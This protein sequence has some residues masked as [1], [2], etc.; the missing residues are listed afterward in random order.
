MTS[1]AATTTQKIEAVLWDID[2]TLIDSEDLHYDV[3]A[4]WC[5][6]RGYVL[7]K[8][9]N[10][11]L[12]G[13]SMAE[14]WQYLKT[15]HDFRVDGEMFSRECA[16]MYCAALRP[17]LARTESVAVFRKIADMNIPLACVSNGDAAVVEANLEILGL[18]DLIRFSISGEDISSGKPDP[19][20]YLL[21]AKKMGVSPGNCIAVEDSLV[22]VTSASAAGMTVIAWPEPGTSVAGYEAASYFI[23]EEME[24]PWH[25][26]T[27]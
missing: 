23:R 9:D 10:A 21:A 14:K 11:V 19:E 8:E 13:K 26:I 1:L 22:G 25:L 18:A 24:F 16:A 4:D 2:G 20:P 12:L 17:E 15:V 7:E 27:S 5:K 6:A 3:I